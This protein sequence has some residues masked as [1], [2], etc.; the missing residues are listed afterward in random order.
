ME[1]AGGWRRERPLASR[2]KS[3]GNM[4]YHTVATQLGLLQQG[5]PGTRAGFNKDDGMEESISRAAPRKV[6]PPVM[7]SGPLVIQLSG[8]KEKMA[9]KE[10]E[11][12]TGRKERRHAVVGLP[13]RRAGPP[14]PHHLSVKSRLTVTSRCRS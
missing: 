7:N 6:L 8:N 9:S 10:S 3:Q 14:L 5:G 1:V 2:N 11:G 12:D 4:I 13:I